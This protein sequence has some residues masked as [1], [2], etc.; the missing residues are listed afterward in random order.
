MIQ[1]DL[2]SISSKNDFI[3]SYKKYTIIA[4]AVVIIISFIFLFVSRSQDHLLNHH[5]LIK[6]VT[7]TGVTEVATHPGAWDLDYSFEVNGNMEHC[8]KRMSTLVGR[9]DYLVNKSFPLIYETGHP[10]NS[11]LLITPRNFQRYDMSFPDS[12]QWVVKHVTQQEL[13]Q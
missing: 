13:E 9:P 6:D 8:T 10:E 4:G 7:V 11:R 3:A 12:L 1:Q 5:E 2:R